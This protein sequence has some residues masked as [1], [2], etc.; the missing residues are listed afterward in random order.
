[1]F[2]HVIAVA[3]LLMEYSG[4]SLLRSSMGL[5][6]CDING[7]VIVLPRL[8]VQFFENNLGLSK[9]DRIGEV[10]ILVR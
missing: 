8:H 4:T 1:M 3:M 2:E 5:S 9:S 7:E 6:K 10:T